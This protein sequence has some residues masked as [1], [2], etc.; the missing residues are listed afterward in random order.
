MAGSHAGIGECPLKLETIEISKITADQSAQPR[1]SINV[2]RVTEYTEDMDRGAQF[3]PLVLFFDGKRHF[4]ADGFHRFYAATNAGKK[5]ITC[6]VHEGG[7]REA[8]LYSCGANASHGMRRTN[9]DK[10]RAVAK[11]LEDPEW[12]KWSNMEIARRCFVDDKTVATIRKD[13][14]SEI[15]SERTYSTKHGTEATMD[16]SAIGRRAEL[17]PD[18]PLIAKSLREI[19][20]YIDMMPKRPSEAIEHFPPEQRYLFPVS[21]IEAMAD[22]LVAFAEAWRE[23]IETEALA[24]A[25]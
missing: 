1:T 8:V 14:T 19:E 13:L 9:E 20:K 11:L 4:L 23:D 3:P 15:A 6:E 17:E 5:S 10:R 2:D 12:S 18:G 25:D 21:K 24:N 16:T 22:W 7:L